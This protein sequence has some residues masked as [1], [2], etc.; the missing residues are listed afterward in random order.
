MIEVRLSG[1]LPGIGGMVRILRNAAGLEDF[2]ISEPSAPYP[3]RR[4]PGH[5]VYVTVLLPDDDTDEEDKSDAGRRT[6]AKLS[7]APLPSRQGGISQ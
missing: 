4:E 2:E 6:A 3:N 5:R 7:A 1:D